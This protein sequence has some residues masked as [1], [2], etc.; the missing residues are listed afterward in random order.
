MQRTSSDWSGV[1]HVPLTWRK[2]L[3]PTPFV[4]NRV[5]SVES[6]S[7]MPMPYLADSMNSARQ[8]PSAI[9][10]TP[11]NKTYPAID[12]PTTRTPCRQSLRRRNTSHHR[13]STPMIAT[14]EL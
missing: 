12:E 6:G 2:A 10:S 5:K 7:W 8:A 4:V 11:K 14:A 3:G 13:P 9:F 1:I